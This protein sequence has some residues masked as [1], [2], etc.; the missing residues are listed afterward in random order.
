MKIIKPGNYE[1]VTKSKLFR[2]KR[3]EGEFEADLS[4]YKPA[5]QLAYMHDGV[6][7]ECKCPCC[8]TTVYTYKDD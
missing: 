1:A 7:A 2:C 3:C 4:E 8:K 6:V 5:S